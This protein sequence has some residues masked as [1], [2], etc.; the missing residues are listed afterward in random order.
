MRDMQVPKLISL[1]STVEHT[2]DSV[3]ATILPIETDDTRVSMAAGPK[4]ASSH[5]QSRAE[6]SQADSHSNTQVALPSQPTITPTQLVLFFQACH[7]GDMQAV[8]STLEEDP[9]FDLNFKNTT[10]VRM[11]SMIATGFDWS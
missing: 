5:N 6:S 8:V 1:P 9:V 11:H 3:Q 10:I 2:D 7:D 4:V